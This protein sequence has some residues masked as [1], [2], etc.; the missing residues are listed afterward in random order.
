MARDGDRMV[1]AV[2][3]KLRD[4]FE[5]HE[6]TPMYAYKSEI[7]PHFRKPGNR[8]SHQVGLPV[9]HVQPHVITLGLYPPDFLT[10]DKPRATAGLDGDGGRRI[11][12]GGVSPARPYGGQ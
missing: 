4:M 6:I 10:G 3:G 7:F 12:R 2:C 11:V 1:A 8:H 5:W 9:G